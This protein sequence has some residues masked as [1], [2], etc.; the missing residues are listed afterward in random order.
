MDTQT[1]PSCAGE[2][3]TRAV[4]C[5]LC[6]K[7]IRCKSCQ[8][9]V[10]ANWRA[11]IQCGSIINE[12]SSP[13]FAQEATADTQAVNTIEYYETERKR[14]LKAQFTNTIGN[15]LTKTVNLL[16]ANRISRDT[17]RER[18][19]VQG[20][21]VTDNGS[22]PLLPFGHSKQEEGIPFE[23]SLDQN[24]K[25]DLNSDSRGSQSDLE[26]LKKFFGQDGEKFILLD[27]RLKASSKR[28]FVRRLA[29]LFLYFRKLEGHDKV[30]RT[31]LNTL[32]KN[33]LWR[34][35]SVS[36]GN[37]RRWLAKNNET[38]H[39]DEG[40]LGLSNPGQDFAV[41]VLKEIQDVSFS[42]SIKEQ[43]KKSSLVSYVSSLSAQSKQR[44][45]GRKEQEK[46]ERPRSG[47]P[48]GRPGPSAVMNE[49]I[50]NGFFK[51]PK[52]LGEIVDHCQISLAYTFKTSDFTAPLA[53]YVHDK[54][55]QRNKNDKEQ[56]EYHE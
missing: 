34:N 19:T 33:T 39:Y 52:T 8:E 9:R 50:E 56:Y 22:Q 54:K 21:I 11:C 18:R 46:K 25:N 43:E 36:D 55:L 2:I 4:Y 15:N 45:S 41:R 24:E 6:T 14:S 7:Q 29:C 37:T 28:D 26:S 48:K 23:G 44:S 27:V 49:L 38:V 13:I 35:V 30:L 3:P 47:S 40:Y 31:T 16:L 53:R 20:N 42:N 1:C 5:P 32:V 51:K 17:I 12:R 10:E